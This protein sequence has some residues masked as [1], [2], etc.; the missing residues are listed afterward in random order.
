VALF[1]N[2]AIAR[3]HFLTWFLTLLVVVVWA[4]EI[5]IDWLRRRYPVMWTRI[6][7]HP[8]RLLLASSLSRLQKVAS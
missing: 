7:A 5:G 4:H 1:Y 8:W 2:G 6:A 3:Y